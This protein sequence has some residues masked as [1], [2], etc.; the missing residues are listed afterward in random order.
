ME[1]KTGEPKSKTEELAD[2]PKKPKM[3]SKLRKSTVINFARNDE[4]EIKAV[5]DKE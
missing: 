2:N 1:E 5:G 4:G 3:K